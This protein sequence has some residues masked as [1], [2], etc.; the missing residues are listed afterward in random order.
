MKQIIEPVDKALLIE[1]INALE[2]VRDTGHGENEIYIFHAST[3]PNLMREVG[4]LR[5]ERIGCKRKTPSLR[6]G[7]GYPRAVCQEKRVF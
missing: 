2:K 5:E 1:E 3:S 7:A 4:R 6:L